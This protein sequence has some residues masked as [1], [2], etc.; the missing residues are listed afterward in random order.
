VTLAKC[1]EGGFAKC[2]RSITYEMAPTKWHLR[3]VERVGKVEGKRV[4]EVDGD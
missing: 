4:R 3:S 2:L 1:G